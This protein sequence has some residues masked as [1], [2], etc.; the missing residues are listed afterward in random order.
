MLFSLVPIK[1]DV[2]FVEDVTNHLAYFFLGHGI[3]TALSVEFVGG[4]TL[5]ECEI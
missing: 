2:S 4:S 1:I 5:R 3:H